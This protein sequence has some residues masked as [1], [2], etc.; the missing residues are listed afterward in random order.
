MSYCHVFGFPEVPQPDNSY[1]VTIYQSGVF[2]GGR[3]DVPGHAVKGQ[4]FDHALPQT[5][6]AKNKFRLLG[7]WKFV[8]S[9]MW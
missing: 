3:S 4:P 2:T 5:G 6:Q 7:E 8:L 9:V 1:T